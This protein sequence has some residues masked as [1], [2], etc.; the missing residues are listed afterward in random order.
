MKS[1]SERERVLGRELDVVGVAPWPGRPRAAG[2]GLHLLGR[3]AQLVL[4]V[5]LAGGDEDVDAGLR[6][7]ADRL[8]AAVD[9]LE[10][11]CATGRRSPGRAPTGRSPATASKSPWLAIG[12]PASMT[13]TPRRASCSAISSFSPTSSEMP[14]RLL[15]V[16]QGGVEDDHLVCHG[17]A[18]LGVSARRRCRVAGWVMP[19]PVRTGPR[20]T[21]K[22]PGPEAQ[23]ARTSTVEVLASRKQE[24]GAMCGMHRRQ[25]SHD[26]GRFVN[27]HPTANLG[28][29]SRRA[30]RVT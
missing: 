1:K 22:P 21:T 19:G 24:D 6:R 27:P 30:G 25:P 14:G 3:H 17:L 29:G 16:A 20:K 12:N 2:L 26:R 9:V 13:S 7:R 28:A 23:E 11:R 10:R 15:A 18:S 8:P 5:D 4:H